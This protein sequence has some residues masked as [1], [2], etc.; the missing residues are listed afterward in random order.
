MGCIYARVSTYICNCA[1]GFV[2]RS[3][4]VELE[5]TP[6]RKV[7]IVSPPNND[8]CGQQQSKLRM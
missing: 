1:S 4:N 6:N 8:T 7:S 5:A 3:Q 2:I